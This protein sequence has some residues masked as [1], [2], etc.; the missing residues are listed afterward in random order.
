MVET[1]AN[2]AL[3]QCLRRLRALIVLPPDTPATGG[4]MGHSLEADGPT[5][6]ANA[7]IPGWR[8]DL[9]LFVTAW[10]AGFVFFLVL[11]G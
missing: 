8:S 2:P 4:L 5:R 1:D 11:I 7:P 3:A 10:A 9:R 6:D